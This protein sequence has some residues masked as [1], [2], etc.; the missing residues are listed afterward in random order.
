MTTHLMPLDA[1]LEDLAPEDRAN[2]AVL[3]G[4]DRDSSV[5]DLCEAARWLYHSKVRSE[6][7]NRSRNAAG[8]TIAFVGSRLL[9]GDALVNWAKKTVAAARRAP[10]SRR[11]SPH[12]PG[13]KLSTDLHE[14][15]GSKIPT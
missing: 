15:L 8:R 12:R 3:W 10:R 11:P 7:V 2:L 4:V 14:T 13:T 6:V 1:M 5:Q 9:A